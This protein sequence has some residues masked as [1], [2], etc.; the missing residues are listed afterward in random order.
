MLL[1]II[2]LWLL[3]ASLGFKIRRASFL[4][5]KISSKKLPYDYFDLQSHLNEFI[6]KT[7][8]DSFNI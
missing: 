6:L 1:Q 2:K 5:S 3:D 7:F 4:I 8:N